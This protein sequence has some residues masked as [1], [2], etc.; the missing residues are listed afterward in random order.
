MARLDV[1]TSKEIPKE[2]I[3][4]RNIEYYPWIDVLRAACWL[5]VVVTHTGF[6]GWWGNGGVAIFFAISGWLITKI[7]LR[8]LNQPNFLS[9]FYSRRVLRI[10]PAYFLA[11]G[12]YAI[13]YGLG[14]QSHAG[15]AERFFQ[16][17]PWF[18]TF[19]FDLFAPP[20]GAGF[21][22]AWS[23]S[24]EERFY[25]VW[26]GLCLLGWK[27]GVS[28]VWIV[29]VPII[30]ITLAPLAMAEDAYANLWFK[31]PAPLLFGCLLA[32]VFNSKKEIDSKVRLAVALVSLTLFSL[33][34]Q[35]SG[36]RMLLGPLGGIFAA[37]L[38]WAC[39]QKGTLDLLPKPLH[40]FAKLGERSYGAY[41]IHIPFCS[42][43]IK[44]VKPFGLEVA[45]PI[46]AAALT[47]L[48]AEGLY[49]LV[50]E[51]ALKRRKLCAQNPVLANTLACFQIC[52]IPAG[53]VLWLLTSG[54]VKPTG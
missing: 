32:L 39:T 49:R 20:G 26:P 34:G 15:T 10:Y 8:S 45:A 27:L 29:A 42:M 9:E 6:P 24:V 36:S 44:L 46:V 31:L 43:A 13:L 12:F 51:P 22:H 28:L 1:T 37:A 5:A 19:N 38:V 47:A 18:A 41:L 48:A 17:I 23:I 35:L 3:S 53:I 4:F 21:G 30:L 16:S 33:L 14:T 7:I 11:L 52:L 54:A 40:L 25:L 50:E 2:P